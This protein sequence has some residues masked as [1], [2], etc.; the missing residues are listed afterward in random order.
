MSDELQKRIQKAMIDHDC[1]PYEK[2]R[3]NH[4]YYTHIE[5][6]TS[7]IM[8]LDKRLNGEKYPRVRKKLFTMLETEYEPK[9][10]KQ[11]KFNELSDESIQG[12]D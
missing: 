1:D 2:F 3:I 5:T 6:I 7:D 4:K 11:V 10:K 8:S 9:F 12:I